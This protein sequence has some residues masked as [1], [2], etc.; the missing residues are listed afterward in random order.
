MVVRSTRVPLS[1][2]TV[3]FPRMCH[4]FFP[5]YTRIKIT[6][7]EGFSQFQKFCNSVV[8][9]YK[10]YLVVIKKNWKVTEQAQE[11]GSG[12]GTRVHDGAALRM[13]KDYKKSLS[14]PLFHA[15]MLKCSN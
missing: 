2:T 14:H 15:V 8:L 7:G 1:H 10:L 5:L 6:H 4:L 11:S 13:D 9:D 3:P 12:G